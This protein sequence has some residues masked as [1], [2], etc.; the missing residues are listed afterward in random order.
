MTSSSMM[1]LNGSLGVEFARLN[2]DGSATVR[3]DIV[4]DKART[5]FDAK[6]ADPLCIVS[7]W[8]AVAALIWAVA[9]PGVRP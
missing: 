4:R 6:R 3:W 2:A 1:V 8:D 7:E 9:Q 5:V